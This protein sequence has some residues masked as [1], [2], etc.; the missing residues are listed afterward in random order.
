MLTH[1]LITWLPAYETDNVF[2][3][4]ENPQDGSSFR[5]KT[6]GWYDA[7]A[8]D[9]SPFQND[10]S[11]RPATEL[12]LG[13]DNRFLYLFPSPFRQGLARIFS[14]QIPTYYKGT[15]IVPEYY[16][17]SSHLPEIQQPQFFEG[18]IVNSVHVS[19][20]SGVEAFR[21]YWKKWEGIH[22]LHD[23]PNCSG[24]PYSCTGH[25]ATECRGKKSRASISFYH[26]AGASLSSVST[27]RH[28]SFAVTYDKPALMED[29]CYAVQSLRSLLTTLNRGPLS[30]D[31][32]LVKT[33]AGEFEYVHSSWSSAENKDPMIRGFDDL[34]DETFLGIWLAAQSDPRICE[35]LDYLT[36][37]F[38]SSPRLAHEQLG[39]LVVALEALSQIKKGGHLTVRLL[40]EWEAE[41]GSPFP[42]DFPK[43][44]YSWRCNQFAHRQDLRK[45]NEAER[46]Q[47]RKD[48]AHIYSDLSA[49]A[50]WIAMNVTLRHLGLP[51]E[52]RLVR[53]SSI[54]INGNRKY[55]I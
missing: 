19:L 38:E 43:R 39:L 25:T 11:P 54:T 17:T 42:P 40:K 12:I 49:F 10:F 9:I 53:L 20:T 33:D 14:S 6:E 7:L 13:T 4:L 15:L 18:Q 37:Y 5:L 45:T 34:P 26:R 44:F 35:V 46:R 28:L 23:A 47:I 36:L 27:S 8:D 51:Q 50:Y 31:S 30:V 41:H 29:A 1:R 32:V 48:F 52:H 24:L 3:E 55:M 22:R 2:A 16:R 21:P